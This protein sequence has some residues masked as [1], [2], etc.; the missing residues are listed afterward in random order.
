MPADRLYR[1]EAADPSSRDEAVREFDQPYG[2]RTLG[3]ATDGEHASADS[4]WPTF[5]ALSAGVVQRQADDDAAR[6]SVDAITASVGGTSGAPLDG[7]TRGRMEGAFGADFSGVRVH[8]GGEAG[9]MGAQAFT[10]GQDLHFAPGQYQPGTPAGDELIGHE[11]THVVQQQQG[12]VAVPQGKGAPINDD[13]SLEAEADRAGAQ[14]ARGEQV[15]IA[16]STDGLRGAPGA[17]QAKLAPAIQCKSKLKMTAGYTETLNWS[18]EAKALIAAWDQFEDV[19]EEVKAKNLAT[20]VGSQFRSVRARSR[21]LEQFRSGMLSKT[22][23]NDHSRRV[24]ETQA[25]EGEI[26]KGKAI[27]EDHARIAGVTLTE[28][29]KSDEIGGVDPVGSVDDERIISKTETETSGESPH[30]LDPRTKVHGP[31]NAPEEGPQPEPKSTTAKAIDAIEIK[32]FDINDLG[33]AAL[34]KLGYQDVE[35][36]KLEKQGRLGGISGEL[37]GGGKGSLG[38]G[39]QSSIKGQIKLLMGKS[40]EATSDEVDLV[41]LFGG[42]KVNVRG[43]GEISGGVKG[44]LSGEGSL[45]YGSE[46]GLEGGLKG[47]ASAFVGT[48]IEVT[49]QV[50]LVDR[51]GKQLAGLTATGGMSLGLG[52]SYEGEISFAGGVLTYKSKSTVSVG[53]GL[54]WGVSAEINVNSLLA[55]LFGY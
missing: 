2:P 31:E 39:M 37:T 36:L 10:R 7:P 15:E 51:G 12:R 13:P 4:A 26:T 27:I 24:A 19:Y 25:I 44:E 42:G 48:S 29:P 49:P 35:A 43:K 30:F 45:K 38:E 46:N 17:V 18:S 8:E 55:K 16:G 32:I 14:A 5:G 33:V 22:I 21:K 20:V 1:D 53:L 23:P 11:L 28:K 3:A 6:P 47:G 41:P 9:A 54:T 40:G 50:R 52:G 34:Q